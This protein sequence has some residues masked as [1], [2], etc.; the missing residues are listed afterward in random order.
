MKINR[1]RFHGFGHWIDRTFT[2]HDG[3][4][5]IE[6]PNESGKST[7]IQGIFA[8][9]YGRN[10]EGNYKKKQKAAWFEQ[11]IPWEKK[12]VYGGEIDYIVGSMRF[13]A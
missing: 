4:N 7:L 2:F 6:A 12:N 3:I 8:L 11:F 10:K 1:V 13:F 9:L 5:L